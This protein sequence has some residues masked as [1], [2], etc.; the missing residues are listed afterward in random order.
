[1][2]SKRTVINDDALFQVI[3]DEIDKLV[4][5]SGYTETK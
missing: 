3:Q 2:K 4:I 5:N 1:M